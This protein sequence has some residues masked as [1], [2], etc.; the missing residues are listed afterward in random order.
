MKP[1]KHLTL[2]HGVSPP[3][4]KP[5]SKNQVQEKKRQQQED[6]VQHLKDQIQL[7]L[8]S[9]NPDERT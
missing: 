8:Q 7:I 4:M 5:S 2:Q 6:N 1:K 9:I 3:T